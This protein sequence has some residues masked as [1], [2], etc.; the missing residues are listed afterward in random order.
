MTKDYL[1]KLSNGESAIIKLKEPIYLQFLKPRIQIMV[2]RKFG[3]G[4]KA[5][6]WFE[7][8]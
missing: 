7:V 6:E 2:W 1:V 5:E 3:I 8:E 4:V